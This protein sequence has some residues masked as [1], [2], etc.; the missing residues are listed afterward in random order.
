MPFS[1]IQVCKAHR[2]DYDLSCARLRH[3][4]EAL[5]PRDIRNSQLLTVAQSGCQD[6]ISAGDA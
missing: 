1:W 4:I 5:P 3:M 2:T 6:M